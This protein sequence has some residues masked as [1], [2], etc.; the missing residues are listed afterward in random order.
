MTQR[1]SWAGGGYLFSLRVRLPLAMLALACLSALAVGLAA[2]RTVS[3]WAETTAAERLALLADSYAQVIERSWRRL[4]AE[5]AVEARSAYAVSRVDELGKWMEFNPQS[6]REVTDYFRDDPAV[7]PADRRD[8]TGS[9]RRT[10]YSWRHVP[11]HE[12]YLSVLRQFGYADIYLVNPNGRVVYSVTKGPEF[13]RLLSDPEL[14]GTGLSQAVAAAGKLPAN[15]QATVDFAPYDL[16]GGQPRAF[17]AQQFRNANG[18]GDVMGTFVV[19][20]DTRFIDE[21]LSALSAS[22]PGIRSYV[23][24]RDG[25]MRSNPAA[26]RDARAPEGTLDRRRLAEA[27]GRLLKMRSRAGDTLVAK[28]SE[29]RL[30]DTTWLLWLTE[31]EASA[32]AVVDRIDNAII[33]AGLSALGPIAIVALL[34]GM[35]VARPIGGLALA[36]TEAAAGRTGMRI[37]GAQRRDEIGAIAASVQRIRERMQE[38]AGMR[39][40]EREEHDR[41]NRAQREQLLSDL[42]ADLERSVLS[43]TAAV[44]AAA[45]GLKITASELNAGV[46][47]TRRSAGTVHDSAARAVASIRSIGT[48]A[49]G[50]CVVIDRLDGDMQSSDHSA[51]SAKDYADRMGAVVDSLAAGASRVS[52]VVG[53][54]SE[55]AAQTNLL[56]LNATIEAARAGEAGR[57]FAVVASE[58]KGLSGQTARATDDIARQIA[59]MNEATSATVEAIAGIRE[60]IGGLSE[61]VR[62]SAETM[63]HQHGVTHEIV[64]DVGTATGE[65]T[66]IG[67]ATSLVSAASAQTAD[68][69]AA[70]ERASAD[71]SE[72]AYRLNARVG[73]FIVQVRAA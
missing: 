8:R 9:D 20:V 36:L 24:G 60:M 68:A 63:R 33:V 31:P 55:I 72:L 64:G 56:A 13:G 35:S 11:I 25:F 26:R 5:V 61:A 40:Q 50:L 49:E 66:R 70:V 21:T 16:I 19:A 23:L 30:G 52:D 44:S 27:D 15:G 67:D 62:R 48:A 45:D 51:R 17:I 65:F 43:A 32:F 46:S 6:L 3:S 53:L 41:E 1:L 2:Y 38:E 14:A 71:L 73:E 29:I 42:A 4:H 54:I 69:A 47:E 28:G 10:V 57:G 58:V 34:L 12:T 59:A 22:S 39:L 18:E 37:P 7:S